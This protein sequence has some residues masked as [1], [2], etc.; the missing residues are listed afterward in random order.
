M[1]SFNTALF[2]FKENSD[3]KPTTTDNSKLF[4]MLTNMTNNS[5]W[6]LNKMIM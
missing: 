5:K 4:S 2:E 3:F 1:K 6:K